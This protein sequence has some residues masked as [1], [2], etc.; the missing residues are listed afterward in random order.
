M[1]EAERIAILAGEGDLPK[2]L[3][4]VASKCLDVTVVS[5]GNPLEWASAY[6][7]V[8][9]PFEKPGMLFK[10]LKSRN[11]SKVVF[12]GGMTRPNLDFKKFDFTMW[13]LAGLLLPALKSGDDHTLRAILALFERRG[14]QVVSA[15]EIAPDL[16]V[17]KKMASAQK[18][19]VQDKRDIDRGIDILKSLAAADVGQGCV[20]SG[21]V[22]LGVETIQGTNALLDFVA[23]HKRDKG[24]VFVKAPKT[25]Q[26]KRVDMPTIGPETI[27]Q[28]AKAG[29][30]GIAL[31]ENG[32]LVIDKEKVTALAQKHGLFITVLHE[33]LL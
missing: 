10:A 2:L 3:A 4:D 32:A 18:L 5:F 24:G 7:E 28:V 23:Q 9:L 14:F 20:V 16:L 19:T 29:L 22:C 27:K 13:T 25:G 6:D 33:G 21:G 26:D 11:I 15:Q 17:D 1:S 30:H 8:V 31:I 12:A